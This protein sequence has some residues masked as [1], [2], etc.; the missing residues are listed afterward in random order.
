MPV[1]F[2][3]TGG[4]MLCA[5]RLRKHR[6]EVVPVWTKKGAAQLLALLALLAATSV[7][8]QSN[9]SITGRVIDENGL[10][11][12]AIVSAS[13]P[14]ALLRRISTLPDGTFTIGS[15]PAGN[16][17]LC[18]EATMD[19]PGIDPFVN[20]CQWMSPFDK[21]V[22]LAAGKT[23]AGVTIPM[24]RGHRFVVRVNDPGKVLPP[25]VGRNA[26]SA[27]AVSIAG[28]KGLRRNVPITTFETTGRTHQI[29]IPF[30]AAHNL[31]VHSGSLSL[32]DG[33]GRAAG[34]A[35]AALI[36]A[37]PASRPPEFIVNV[38]KGVGK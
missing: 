35:Q 12:D 4:G 6:K 29:V 18:A 26:G 7:N 38:S 5:H 17:L 8:G 27:F 32:S 23:Q 28:P 31:L 1:R 21:P 25:P 15:L 3:Q 37:T 34:Q 9:A 14:A 36:Q 20:S 13:G 30:N 24:Q 19:R 33:Q 16:Y 2:V 11:V 22:Q 10:G